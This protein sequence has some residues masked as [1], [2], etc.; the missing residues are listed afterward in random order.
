MLI[1]SWQHRAYSSISQETPDDDLQYP[2]WETDV[3]ASSAECRSR[4]SGLLHH[5]MLQDATTHKT[6]IWVSVLL[7]PENLTAALVLFVAGS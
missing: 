3:D 1:F 5:V 4:C 6:I 7:V 2:G